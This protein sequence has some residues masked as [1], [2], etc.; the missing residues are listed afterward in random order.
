MGI[1]C[2]CS[3]PEGAHR[4]PGISGWTENDVGA[5]DGKAVST[6]PERSK[7]WVCDGVVK[8]LTKKVPE[9]LEFPGHLVGRLR[10]PAERG[11]SVKAELHFLHS[12]H[13][14][15]PGRPAPYH[16][17]GSDPARGANL[18]AVQRRRRPVQ[19]VRSGIGQSLGSRI[20]VSIRRVDHKRAG[21]PGNHRGTIRPA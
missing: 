4:N 13:C 15:P 14:F 2:G 7:R 17:L 8:S 19:L 20:E 5:S 18:F 21:S 16:C 9:T 3:Y 12:P 6:A 11:S 1:R 10:K